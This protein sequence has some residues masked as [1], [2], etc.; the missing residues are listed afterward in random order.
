MKVIEF[1]IVIVV[2]VIIFLLLVIVN[3]AFKD[4]D[5]VYDTDLYRCKDLCS[6]TESNVA[7]S[8]VCDNKL[9]YCACEKEDKIKVL[10]DLECGY[11][12]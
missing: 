8:V 3:T 12:K 7:V 2:F 9:S 1:F 5:I 6:L 10:I 11:M 4:P